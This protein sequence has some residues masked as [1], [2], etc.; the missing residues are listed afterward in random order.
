MIEHYDFD[1][2]ILSDD[3]HFVFL[4]DLHEVQHGTDNKDL[5][6]AIKALNPECILIGGD[7]ITSYKGITKE[8][9]ETLVFI[10]NLSKAFPVV[11]VPGN[12]ERALFDIKEADYSHRVTQ[13][14]KDD[15]ERINRLEKTLKEC[16]IPLLRNESLELHGGKV[17][18]Y[19]LDLSLDY[20]RRIIRRAPEDECIVN[21]LGTP[22]EGHY[23]IMLA[24]D[25]EHFDEYSK[26]GCDLVLSGHLHGGIIRIPGLGG[27]IS[28]QLKLFP[29]YDA[30]VF[31]KG[32]SKMLLTRGIGNH[33]VPVRIFNKAEVC[34]VII[35]NK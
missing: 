16:D 35:H 26:W 10:R 22:E 24:H 11:Y 8:L 25:P 9:D 12:H 2:K 17:M 33:S 5:L 19:G 18:V 21:L 15:I 34:D 30:G 32:A 27:V 31:S 6:D 1:S 29:K 20:Y 7:M 23:N 14:E 4:S 13:K 28:P 3:F